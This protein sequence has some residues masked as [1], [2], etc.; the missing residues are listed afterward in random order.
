M[1]EVS[2]TDHSF[3][4]LQDEYNDLI[5]KLGNYNYFA[6]HENH[7]ARINEMQKQIRHY[8]VLRNITESQLALNTR[9]LNNNTEKFGIDK[10]LYDS[11]FIS[12]LDYFIKRFSFK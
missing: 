6:T 4:H 1:F 10:G 11:G 2:E 5:R 3:G 8:Q 7:S 9:A 12:R